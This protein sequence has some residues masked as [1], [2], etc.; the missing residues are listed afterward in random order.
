MLTYIFDYHTNHNYGFMIYP[1]TRI[2]ITKEND[3]NICVVYII[4]G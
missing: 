3:I 1:L 2:N 4:N